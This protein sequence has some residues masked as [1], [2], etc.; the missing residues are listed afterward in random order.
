M[1]RKIYLDNI[2][3]MTVLLVII[4]H[5]IY[6]FNSAGVISNFAVKGI[7]QMDV[8][9]YFVYPW[10]MSLL[11]VVA[12][13]SAHAALQTKTGKEFL[14]A[15]VQRLLIPS[16]AGI[17]LIGWFNGW[18][19]DTYVDMFKENRETIPGFVKYLIYC[20]SGTGALWF[21]HELFGASVVLV[22]IKAIDKK[23]RLAQLGAKCKL[24]TLF[25]LVL[26]YWI[27]SMLFNT[28]VIEIYRNGFYIF[29]FLL[30]YYVFSREELL[31]Q[32]EKLRIPLLIAS[33][34]CGIAYTAYYYGDNY[35]TQDV[36]QHPFTNAYAW[37]MILAI[38]S[39]AKRAFNFTNKFSTYMTKANFGFY[40]LHYP[41]L[42]FVAYMTQHYLPAPMIVHY[43]VNTILLLLLLP[44]VYEIL[45][46]VPVLRF[47]LLGIS[48]KK[49]PTISTES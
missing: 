22:I 7:P 49:T 14:K 28:P 6:I 12:G 37:L 39:W 46:R 17:F 3:W 2:R 29:S 5:I 8:V 1:N 21:A 38:F 47:L 31:E 36:L 34:I 33:L 10:F 40:V 9:L 19:T 18:V 11:F 16:I 27:S 44:L 25:L 41:V 42:S 45:R 13:V 20:L 35:T 4:Y 32:L 15:R 26:P 43:I 23:D 48:K 24:W 30:G